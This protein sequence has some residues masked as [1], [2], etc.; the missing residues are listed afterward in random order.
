MVPPTGFAYQSTFI[1][2]VRT[3]SMASTTGKPWPAASIAIN[4]NSD[5]S[6]S[7]GQAVISTWESYIRLTYA[8]VKAAVR[9]FFFYLFPSYS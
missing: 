2:Q 7:F 3:V 5:A 1:V 6:T 9:K 4:L 8:N